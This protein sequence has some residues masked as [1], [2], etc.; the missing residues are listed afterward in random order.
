MIQSPAEVLLKVE[1]VIRVLVQE[2]DRFIVQLSVHS[3]YFEGGCIYATA[4]CWSW[5][6]FRTLGR[7]LVPRMIV[8]EERGRVTVV[9]LR[10]VQDR[11][12]YH[13]R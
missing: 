13:E 1:D 6:G 7:V 5:I 12:G 2:L 8:G 4:I 11:G 9:C 10:M 3:K